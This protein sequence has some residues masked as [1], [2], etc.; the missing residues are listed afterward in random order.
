MSEVRAI[1]LKP[2][3]T[4]ALQSLDDLRAKLQSGEIVMFC[5]VGIEKDDSTR[6]WVGSAHGSKTK[7]QWMGALTNL[8]L[9]IWHE[10][11][12]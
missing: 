9:T 8:L 5:A 6:M 10:E 3:M 4:N 11:L 2:D 7:L 12:K 1:N